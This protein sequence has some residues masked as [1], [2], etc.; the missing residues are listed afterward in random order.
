M[1][2]HI[3]EKY[4]I[5]DEAKVVLYVGNISRNKNQLQMVEA[6]SHLPSYVASNVWVLFCGAANDASVILQDAIEKVPYAEHLIC[7]G[8]VPKEDMPQYYQEADAVALLSFSEGFGLSLIEG[9]YFGLPCM[10]F[11]DME[12][13]C[14][15]YD[16]CA[17]VAIGNRDTAT[18]TFAL[19]KLLETHWD[20]HQIRTFSRR[21][22][23]DKMAENYMMAYNS[24]LKVSSN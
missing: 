3:R 20:A 5:P 16:E 14:D 2:N 19:Q 11:A 7:C 23:C 24:V 4:S 18:V 22:C 8:G 13:F 12:A 17:V 15:I 9:M 10:M 21:F 6:F 1:S